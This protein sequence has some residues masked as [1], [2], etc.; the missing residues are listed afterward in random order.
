MEN[1]FDKSFR[2]R[3]DGHRSQIDLDKFWSDLEPKL[4]PKKKKRRYFF[5]FLLPLLLGGIGY[6]LYNTKM[7]NNIHLQSLSNDLTSDS[8]LLKN[9][10]NTE[11]IAE[12]QK[13]LSQKD[14]H[15]NEYVNDNSSNN[16]DSNSNEIVNNQTSQTKNH[17]SKNTSSNTSQSTTSKITK[18]SINTAAASSTLS[19]TNQKSKIISNYSSQE[20]E[21]KHKDEN[22]SNIS[23]S[24]LKKS[25][26]QSSE[27]NISKSSHLNPALQK[28]SEK[29][30]NNN[31]ADKTQST[32]A[33]P[34]N[35]TKNESTKEA[36]EA[37]EVSLS[38]TTIN[39]KRE[40]SIPADS[41]QL[42]E[43]NAS[44]LQKQDLT[45]DQ[46]IQKDLELTS[47]Q[48]PKRNIQYFIRPEFGLGT[49]FKSFTSSDTNLHNYLS[50]RKSSEL[51]LEEWNAGLN[52]GIKWNKLSLETGLQFTQ[53]NEQF[54]YFQS[55]NNNKFG[56]TTIR[57]QYINNTTDT[58][59]GDEWYQEFST[60]H[61]IH[62]NA[63]Q[64]WNIPIRASYDLFLI[65]KWTF[66]LQGGILLS[67]KNNMKGRSIND[68]LLI[69][70]LNQISLTPIRSQLGIGVSGG[71]Y[72][73]YRIRN[74]IYIYNSFLY[75]RFS[76]SYLDGPLR[77][78][79]KSASIQFGLQYYF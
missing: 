36:K 27:S 43:D 74:N 56:P 46:I 67:I 24:N 4:P 55:T 73:N 77:L 33:T 29:L 72:L 65:N 16:D 78:N 62:Y 45:K 51:I 25:E 47:R 39:E 19:N 79:Y 11:P 10:T 13:N 69:S 64:N 54:E 28:D 15:Q 48:K 22:I 42:K 37:Q 58:I 53:K 26:S 70:N 60:R 20:K 57:R 2:D 63:I 50:I 35:D 41:I 71:I 31:I 7:K 59:I 75:Q 9:R 68:S 76:S 21:V 23:S 14:N 1:N 40:N 3:L 38:N 8:L 32:Q 18:T 66:G 12:I 44:I 5:W 61:V 17:N 6:A 52:I 30:P 49:F 34:L